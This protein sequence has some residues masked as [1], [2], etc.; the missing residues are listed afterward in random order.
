MDADSGG[1]QE[2]VARCEERRGRRRDNFGAQLKMSK[3]K[4][5]FGAF[6]FAM[7]SK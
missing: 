6:K 1:T 3:R 7:K 5:S 2:K 4:T